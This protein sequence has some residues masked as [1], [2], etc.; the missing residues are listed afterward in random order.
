MCPKN[1]SFV[2]QLFSVMC[3]CFQDAVTFSVFQNQLHQ[4]PI[5]FDIVNSTGQI[6]V[7]RVL[8]DDLTQETSYI[9]S[10]DFTRTFNEF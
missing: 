7:K 4:A 6:V 9:V 5:Y 1:I 8:T 10:S 3:L 2:C